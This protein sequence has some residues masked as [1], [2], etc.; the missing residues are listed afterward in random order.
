MDYVK[1]KHER[2]IEGVA[3]TESLRYLYESFYMPLVFLILG[4]IPVLP[5]SIFQKLEEDFPL[6]EILIALSVLLWSLALHT[7]TTILRRF[8]IVPWGITI[9]L[10]VVPLIIGCKTEKQSAKK[11]IILMGVACGMILLSVVLLIAFRLSKFEK[12]AYI[13][14]GLSLAFA[15]QL[16]G[17]TLNFED[18]HVL[19]VFHSEFF[20]YQVLYLAG[21]GLKRC[22][23]ATTKTLLPAWLALIT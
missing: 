21:Q 11:R 13:S 8:I 14:T 22:G 20:N 7:I 1:D 3:N 15:I 23:N 4:A 16:V 17:Q 9:I 6:N 10:A 12:T 18:I 2:K 5:L 19:F